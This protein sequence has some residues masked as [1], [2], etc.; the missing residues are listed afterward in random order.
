M[1]MTIVLTIIAGILAF[2][3]ASLL[4]HSGYL[5]QRPVIQ[6]ADTENAIRIGRLKIVTGIVTAILVAIVGVRDYKERRDRSEQSNQQNFLLNTLDLN[7]KSLSDIQITINLKDKP[8]FANLKG[9]IAKPFLSPS[10]ASHVFANDPG[11]RNCIDNASA[12]VPCSYEISPSLDGNYESTIKFKIKYPESPSPQE[13]TYSV[14]IEHSDWTLI[15]RL[16]RASIFKEMKILN[17]YDD[18]LITAEE[19]LPKSKI[20]VSNGHVSLVL[21]NTSIHLDRLHQTKI[22]FQMTGFLSHEFPDTI[23]LKSDD[24]RV[25]L[26]QSFKIDWDKGITFASAFY[27]DGMT[28]NKG[29][30]ISLIST[31]QQLNFDLNELQKK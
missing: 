29:A 7:R 26:D 23:Q 9:L 19:I 21:K 11:L 2:L 16:L 27:E 22:K 5:E 13:N 12:D 6:N 24:L 17:E 10:F 3:C 8:A 18:S 28:G 1:T 4:A 20:L 15:N 14:M 31:A 30:G 25:K